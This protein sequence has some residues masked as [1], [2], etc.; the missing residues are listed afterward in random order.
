MHGKGN[1][2]VVRGRFARVGGVAVG[3][4]FASVLAHAQVIKAPRYQSN[5]ETPVPQL[6][7]PPLP[8]AITPHG[9]VVEDVVVRVN[10][11]II[12]RSDVERAQAQMMQEGRQT[13]ISPSELSLRQKDMLRDMID[14]QLL[15]SRAKEMGLN[16]DSD[17]IRKLDEIRKQNKMESLDDLEKAALQ[18]GVSFE[19]FKAQIRNQ[20]LTQQVVRDEVGRR[21]QLSQ[22]D[23]SKYYEDHK[24]DF[25][26]PE[27]IRLSEILVPLPETASAAE[28]AQAEAKANDLKAKETQ[29]TDFAELAKKSSGGPSAAQGGELGL[30]KRGALAKVLEDQTFSL[31]VG[32]STQPVRTRQGF[33]ILKVT[34]HDAAGPAPM[35][36][37]EPQIQEA[38]YM[39]QMQPA[40]RVY[41]TKLR[42]ESYIDLQPGF[43][44]SGSSSR[45]TKPLF[46][47]Y[48]P[49]PVKKKK[50]KQ[51]ARFERNG[52]AAAL[53]KKNVAASPDTTGTRTLTGAEA[54]AAVDPATGL[55]VLP[56]TKIAS[57]GP[58]NAKAPKRT[59]REKIRYGQAPRNPLPTGPEDLSS[60]EEAVARTESGGAPV[61][62]SKTSPASATPAAKAAEVASSTSTVAD[63]GEDAVTPEE[64][65][66]V[67]TR[68][69]SRA[70]EEK[71]KKVRVLSAKQQERVSAKPLPMSSAEQATA[72]TQAAPLG[73]SGDTKKKPKK[74]KR[75]KGAAKQRLGD[76][77]TEPVK[78][79]VAV[80]QTAN[81]ALA[82]V[83]GSSSEAPLPNV[84]APGSPVTTPGNAVPNSSVPRSVPNGSDTTL[85]P[86]T[87]PV[88][89]SP[90]QEQ[91][92]P[93]TQPP[94]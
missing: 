33:V 93:A 52:R 73:L 50:L 66:K 88:P 61:A 68:F 12:N 1:I 41:L 9:T 13:N 89:G 14:Q 47:A 78:A 77:Q 53:A 20:L 29:G 85:P 36:E 62:G 3:L 91:P 49:P 67:K 59:K 2:V 34:E 35:K 71:D 92:L 64:P 80:D 44:D 27:Q 48:A 25:E 55:A 51:R 42:E 84:P 57:G 58:G 28:I 56:A 60:G 54:Q 10:D 74:A 87:Q 19:D 46:T 83:G 26:Q 15:L 65:V 76:R 82:P 90:Q 86:V 6:S 45:E 8:A 40:L 11:Q 43:V 63:S 72:Q 24:K 7:L 21:L 31:K 81:P 38:M 75:A 69:S 4:L 79:P 39:Q 5:V 70:K 22:A 94:N 37:V 30:F 32:E 18:Q 17:V 23:E 16:A